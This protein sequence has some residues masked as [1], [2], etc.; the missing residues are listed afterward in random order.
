MV[1]L[2]PNLDGNTVLRIPPPHVQD[3]VQEAWVAYLAGQDPDLAIW[4]YLARLRRAERRY[5]CFS[6]LEPREQERIYS[7]LPD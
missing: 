5:V 3:A 6:Q 7:E 4:S 2:Q 1:P